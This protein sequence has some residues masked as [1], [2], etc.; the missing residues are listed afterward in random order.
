MK[1]NFTEDDRAKKARLAA[2]EA[3]LPHWMIA[4]K[5]GVSPACLCGWRRRG[6]TEDQFVR[7]MVAISE[8]KKEAEA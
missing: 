5:L 6:M 8:L 3:N 7:V 4:E 2:A 1:R